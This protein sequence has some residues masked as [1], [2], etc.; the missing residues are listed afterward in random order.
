MLLK[1]RFPVFSPATPWM[2]GVGGG[3]GR[4]VCVILE[5]EIA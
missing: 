3:D 1:G 2:C 5:E 4:V